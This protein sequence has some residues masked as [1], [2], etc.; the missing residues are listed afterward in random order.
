MPT[1]WLDSATLPAPMKISAKVPMSSATSEVESLLYIGSLL[2]DR[3]L[4]A[5]P[6]SSVPW[7]RRVVYSGRGPLL[8]GGPEDRRAVGGRIYSG[9]REIRLRK[10]RPRRATPAAG[11]NPPPWH[12]RGGSSA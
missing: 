9:R 6:S 2:F 1:R 8:A 12:G 11:Y 3:R 5:R 7:Q 4:P 10:A